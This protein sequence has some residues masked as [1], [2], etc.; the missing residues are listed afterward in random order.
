DE[1]NAFLGKVVADLGAAFGSM[2][3]YIGTKLGLH[4]ALADSDG[5]TPA[6]LAEKSGT[7]ERYVRE[8]LLNQAA[9]EYVHYDP[10][11]GKYS[12]LPEQKIALTDENSPFYVGGG[13]YVVKALMNAQ[14]RITESFQKGGGMLWGEHDNDMFVGTE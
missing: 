7:T 5:L 1:M 13:F 2:L 9:G 4:Q 3:G 12:L 8:W 11:T 6:E 10:A 14:P